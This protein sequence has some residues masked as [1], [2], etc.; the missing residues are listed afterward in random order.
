MRAARTH[1]SVFLSLAV[2]RTRS[3]ACDTRAR[4]RVEDARIRHNVRDVLCSLAYPSVPVF[5]SV[6]SKS[7]ASSTTSAAADAALFAGFPATVLGPDFSCSCIIPDQVRD[8]R[9]VMP[10]ACSA[11]T[12]SRRGPAGS[13]PKRSS[14]RSPGS[15]RQRV[16]AHARFCDHT[17][18]VGHLHSVPARGPC[19]LHT[20]S[21]S[22]FASFAARRAA[23]ALAA[24]RL[25]YARPCQRFATPS[26]VVDA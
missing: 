25:A 12:P 1:L 2:V 20:T 16:Y 6:V 3:S 9:L 19:V 13:T 5:R 15:Q 8:L 18:P 24:R 21:A 26:R 14:R 4:R 10:L 17:G 23:G 11:T 7:R 22:G